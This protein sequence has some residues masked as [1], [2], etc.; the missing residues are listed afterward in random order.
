MSEKINCG[1]YEF[2]AGENK[3]LR[4]LFKDLHGLGLLMGVI[5][6]LFTVYLLVAYFD[7]ASLMP[8]S[9]SRSMILNAVDY[10]LWII[11]ALLIVYVSASVMHLARPIRQIVETKGADMENLWH[12]LNDL[13]RMV[14]ICF[15]ALILVAILMMVSLLLLIFVF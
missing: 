14:A 9:E 1:K 7:P 10:G 6:L 2:S 13:T 12:F 8:V 3:V 5:G 15:Y 11:I 4:T